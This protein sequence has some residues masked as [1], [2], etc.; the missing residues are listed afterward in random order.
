M[1]GTI[2]GYDV[3]M[4]PNAGRS[5]GG[6]GTGMTAL[7]VWGMMGHDPAGRA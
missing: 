4:G 7:M 3:G 2:M 1:M 5:L 6:T